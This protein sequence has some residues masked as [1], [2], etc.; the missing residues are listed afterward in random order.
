MNTTA[1]TN[2]VSRPS[3]WF[4]LLGGAA[5]WTIHLMFAYVAAEFG[6][7][8]RFSEHRYLGIS[9]VAWMVLVLTAVTAIASA[10]ATV[11]AYRSHRRLQGGANGSDPARLAE[12][13]TARAGILTSAIFTFVILFETIP[14]FFYLRDC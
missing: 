8:S 5:A 12:S 10:I 13:N 3:L 11:V 9:S 14:I 2:Q 1:S 6:C 7:V 4:G